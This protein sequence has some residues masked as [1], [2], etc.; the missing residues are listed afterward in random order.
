MKKT[1]QKTGDV[2]R[3]SQPET[4]HLAIEN[5]QPQLP[6]EN[7]QDDTQ[8]GVLND[9]SLENTLTNMKEKQKRFF[10]VKKD[11]NGQRFWNGT[12][13]EISGHSRVEIK[14]KTFNITPNPQNV[15]TD[16]TGKSLKK[17]R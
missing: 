8:P 1:T 10:Q 2:I 14:S 9:V 6:I 15:F 12:P 4:P 11:Q 5:S 3:E 13:V 16:A 7:N 17:I